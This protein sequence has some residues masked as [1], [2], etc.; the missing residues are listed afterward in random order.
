MKLEIRQAGKVKIVD[1]N[2]NITIGKGD[3]LME[4]A[5]QE[6]LQM[7][8]KKIVI[9]LKHVG[10]IDSAGLGSLL[11]CKK[12]AA[13]KNAEIILLMPSKKVHDLFVMVKL[14]EIYQILNDELEAVGSF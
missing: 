1:L 13:D 9:N 3:V 2:G 6:L 12:R 8:Q 14:S 4:K 11:V 5:I 7:G 10:Y